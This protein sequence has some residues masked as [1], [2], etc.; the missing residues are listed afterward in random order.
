[1]FK[2][3]VIYA[4]G[5]GT[6]MLPL[7]QYVPKGLIQIKGIPLIDYALKFLKH[8]D[9]EQI[10][11]TYSYKSE[12]ILTYLKDKVSGF[13]NTTNKDNSYFLY[14][15]FIKHIDEPIVCMPC[16]IIVNLDLKDVYNK[17][18][19]IQDPVH[20][21]IPVNAKKGISGDYI[22]TSDNSIIN[23]DR[24]TNTGIYA[25]GIQI[26][27]PALL[28]KITK[29]VDNFYGVWKQLINRNQL[30]LINIKPRTWR[31]YDS[32]NDLI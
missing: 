17:Y 28:N 9:I 6:R 23:L 5:E 1:M 18:C 4:G 30:H 27:T 25:C 3:A 14:N 8:N 12:Q 21:L 20:A 16:D 7:T 31:A 29:P 13:I 15:S 19:Q 11:V 26:T 22:T 2:Y 24:N 10:Y 32:I